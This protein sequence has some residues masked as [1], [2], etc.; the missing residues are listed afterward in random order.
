ML[1][2]TVDSVGA[3]D[4]VGTADVIGTTDV[5]LTVV[6]VATGIVPV[7]SSLN[8]ATPLSSLPS[9]PASQTPNRDTTINTAIINTTIFLV[10]VLLLLLLLLLLLFP[11]WLE[12]AVNHHI[13]R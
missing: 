11:I 5:S 9:I 1:G 13:G 10:V 7:D 2:T 6:V 3:L 4:V 12:N 8:A